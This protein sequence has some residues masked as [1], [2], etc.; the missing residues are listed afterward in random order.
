LPTPF[1]PM[2]KSEDDL[3]SFEMYPE[4]DIKYT[5]LAS[6]DDPFVMW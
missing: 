5:V 2:V 3:S 6:N 4:S 1:Q